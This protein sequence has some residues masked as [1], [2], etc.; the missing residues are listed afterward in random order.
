MPVISWKSICSLFSLVLKGPYY[1][2]L[3]G[4]VENV[5]ERSTNIQ[6]L[7]GSILE[8]DQYLRDLILQNLHD[9]S[10]GALRCLGFAYSD[11]PSDF[12]TYD[13]SE[14]HPAHQQLLNPSNYSSIESNLTFVGFV[15]L[16]VSCRHHYIYW[17]FFYRIQ[18]SIESS[19]TSLPFQ[20]LKDPLRKELRQA[21]AD[22]RTAGIRVMV[23][24]EDNKSTAES[25]CRE[26][27]VFEA[28][29]DISSRSLT[30]KEFM[31]VKDQKNHLR[32]TGGLLFSRAEPK[33]K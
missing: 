5:L 1:E 3:Q 8:L 6:L 26:I 21:I 7:D 31:D 13:G 4:A 29:E 15:G 16:R 23:I 10:M 18:S 11:V 25:I 19:L 30:G 12:A 28:G 20:C 32:Q 33:H 14:D 27:G 9:M 24:T 22:Y 17:F 2:I